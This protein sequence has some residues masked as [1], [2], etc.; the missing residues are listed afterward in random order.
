MLMGPYEPYEKARRRNGNSFK[1][2]NVYINLKKQLLKMG[3]RLNEL[4]FA[5]TKFSVLLIRLLILV[6]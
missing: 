2:K 5:M 1:S 4:T 6:R 3:R